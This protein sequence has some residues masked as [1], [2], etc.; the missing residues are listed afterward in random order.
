MKLCSDY[1]QIFTKKSLKFTLG[2][3]DSFLLMF[4]K[5][6]LMGK[7]EFLTPSKTDTTVL[8]SNKLPTFSTKRRML[9]LNLLFFLN[10]Y[11][12][13]ILRKTRGLYSIIVKPITQAQHV[14]WPIIFRREITA[15]AR[16][17]IPRVLKM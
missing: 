5:R 16:E 11:S 17:K 3:S 14:F 6:F 15:E 8:Q 4:K 12:Q 7:L 10:L 13:C 1:G 2:L 9:A